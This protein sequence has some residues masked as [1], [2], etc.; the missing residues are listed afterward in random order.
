MEI[1][2]WEVEGNAWRGGGGIERLTFGTGGRPPGSGGGET[3]GSGGGEGDLVRSS[4]VGGSSCSSVGVSCISSCPSDS[5]SSTYSISSSS[6]ISSSS[7]IFEY[8]LK[9]GG[10]GAPSRTNGRSGGEGVGETEWI[11]GDTL[12]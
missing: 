9:D 8:A 10:L 4:K 11:G 12:D 1:S 7:S 6:D 2:A 5:S 3:L